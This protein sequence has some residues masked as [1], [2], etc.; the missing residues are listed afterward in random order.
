MARN[1]RL[2][3]QAQVISLLKPSADSAG[4]T[5]AYVSLSNAHKAYIVVY[6]NQG[7]AATILLSPLQSSG[8]AGSDSK[9]LTAA[10]PIAVNLDTDTTPSDI[11]TIAT[12]ATT[13]TT[14]AGT[15]SKIVIFEIDPIESMDINNKFNHIAVSTGASNASNITSALLI[16]TPLRFAQQNPP[17]A[18]V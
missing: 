12:A 1:F 7:N 3:E 6:V 8:I 10:A 14:D 17:T 4:R 9:A 5:S 11:M 13:Y 16:L 18:N 2:W 15:K